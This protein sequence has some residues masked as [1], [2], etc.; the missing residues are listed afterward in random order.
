MQTKFREV[1]E[2]SDGDL[3]ASYPEYAEEAKKAKQSID[4]LKKT[5]L[6][7]PQIRA[8]YDMGGEPSAVYLLRRGD[9]QFVEEQ[10]FPG[11]PEVFDGAVEP[12]QI[13]SPRPGRNQRKSPGSGSR[14]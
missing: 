4:E 3:S 12:I 1:L 7:E 8:L 6:P 2:I 14:G 9:P 5:L 11:S 13:V 10:V